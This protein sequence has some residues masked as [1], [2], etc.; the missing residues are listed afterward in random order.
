MLDTIGHMSDDFVRH[1][2]YKTLVFDIP[3]LPL[4]IRDTDSLCKYLAIGIRLQ[5][6][7]PSET[8]DLLERSLLYLLYLLTMN[9]DLV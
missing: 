2:S 6:S 5:A 3:F 9:Y 7:C 1:V 8:C 4:G